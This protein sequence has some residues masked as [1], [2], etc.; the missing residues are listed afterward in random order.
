MTN[1]KIIVLLF[2]IIILYAFNSFAQLQ[3]P[4]RLKW[5][6]IET[7]HFLIHFPKDNEELAYKIATKAEKIHSTLTSFLKYFPTEKTNIVVSD[8]YD[9]VFGAAAPTFYSTIYICP[10]Q[11]NIGLGHYDD[12]LDLLLLHEYTHILDMDMIGGVPEV[13]RMIIGRLYTPN[14]FCPM[15]MIEGF[16]VLMET[17]LTNGG[18]GIDPYYDMYLRMAFLENNVNHLDQNILFFDKWPAG[19]SPYLYGESL[20]RYLSEQKGTDAVIYFRKDNSKKLLPFSFGGSLAYYWD[21]S[22]AEM[23]NRWKI[24]M[25]KKYSRQKRE[26]EKGGITSTK[27][28]TK[29]GNNTWSPIW[30]VDNETI[31][32]FNQNYDEHTALKSV[33]IETGRIASLTKIN[34]SRPQLSLDIAGKY[35]YF[36]QFEINK[37]STL[38]SDIYSYNFTSEKLNR[39]TKNKRA[40]DHDIDKSGNILF[41]VNNKG[42]TDLCLR[43]YDGK[44]TILISCSEDVYFFNPRISP[45]GRKL[46]LS[47]WE[48]G[49]FRDIYIYDLDEK[50]LRPIT[51]DRAWDITPTWSPDGEFILFS[52]DRIGVYNIF[53]YRIADS[54]FF[55]VTNVLGGAFCPA[56]SNDGKKIAFVDYSSVGFDIH[57][58][59]TPKFENLS[60]FNM[61]N[62]L[63]QNNEL[64][65]YG[66]RKNENAMTPN[67]HNQETVIK[68]QHSYNPFNTLIKPIRFPVMTV[69]SDSS[70]VLGISLFGK[71]VLNQHLYSI[72]V[73]YSVGHRRPA[74]IIDYLNSQFYPNFLV[75]FE[76]F[77]Y[78]RELADSLKADEDFYWER[79]QKY[80]LSMELPIIKMRRAFSLNIGLS[81]EKRTDAQGYF[82]K[83]ENPY[84]QGQL[85][86]YFANLFYTDAHIYPRSISY[87][88]GVTVNI[89]FQRY[90]NGLG[91]DLTY[92]LGEGSINKYFRMPWLNHNVISLLALG[93]VTDIQKVTDKLNPEKISIRGFKELNWRKRMYGGTAE[94]RFPLVNVE[95]GYRTW[96]IYLRQIHSD[97]FID[98]RH[99]FDKELMEKDAG[100]CG[101]ELIFD[102]MVIYNLPMSVTF[103]YAHP[104]EVEKDEFS[105]KLYWRL[106]LG[107]EKISKY[108]AG[109]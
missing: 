105:S 58:M 78:P 38:Y 28:I 33:D 57:I 56:V 26:I 36:S 91:S 34:S 22:I 61:N 12:F 60:S 92:Y 79:E 68:K 55:Q 27:Q 100:S 93:K 63:S 10:T 64:F 8:L 89:G 9:Q 108:M 102:F 25:H 67:E 11:F 109:K 98:Y 29:N 35:L 104:L 4:S 85:C 107:M 95:R 2:I 76:D 53:A 46:A 74:F 94:Y 3:F 96:P 32:F 81:Y 106:A 21:G 1:K 13:I 43:G 103:G 48:K 24:D 72:L 99:Y 87:E 84:F 42:K 66:Y 75:H 70:M 52:S 51:E 47:I 54:V 69:D 50:T 80:A 5:R 15:W 82:S 6:T 40:F 83:K 88:D 19:V 49:G 62:S 30:S 44:E 65:V 14:L 31:F 71:D 18:R 39:L 77:V 20:Y 41:V 16:A 86:S 7:D 37:N 59:D 101:I 97:C 17:E 45:N 23:Y 90:T 73:S